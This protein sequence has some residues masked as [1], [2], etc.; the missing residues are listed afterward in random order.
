MTVRELTKAES[1]MAAELFATSDRPLPHKGEGTTH[2]TVRFDP[3][4][5][6]VIY[7][8]PHARVNRIRMPRTVVLSY[9]VDAA[10]KTP[11]GGKYVRQTLRVRTEDGRKWTGTVKSGTDVVILRAI[12][13]QD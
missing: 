12:K 1:K 6:G 10:A 9:K 7:Y 11:S 3:G 8:G 2:L 13:S 5:P 4:K